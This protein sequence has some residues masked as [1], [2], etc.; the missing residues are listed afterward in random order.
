VA[1]QKSLVRPVKN[2][3]IF[4]QC[5]SLG[6]EWR[7]RGPVTEDHEEVRRPHGIV[8]GTVGLRSQ[9]ADCKTDR[10]KWITRSGEVITRYTYPDG[11]S[12]HG[13]DRLSSQQWRS[14]F[15]TRLFESSLAPA[16]TA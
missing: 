11:Y 5:R 1:R 15:V 6:H 14:Q 16:A 2:P 8:W 9:C 3:E 7:H 4:A 10:I 13:D 12:L